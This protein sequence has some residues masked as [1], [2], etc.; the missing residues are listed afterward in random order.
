MASPEQQ[1][2]IQDCIKKL[3]AAELFVKEYALR[4]LI[5]YAVDG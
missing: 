2:E 5:N 4:I 3:D 1:R